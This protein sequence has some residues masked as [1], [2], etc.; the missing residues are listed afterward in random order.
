MW[1]KIEVVPSEHQIIFLPL[2]WEKHCK[3]PLKI[4]FSGKSVKV[5]VQF[6]EAEEIK[7]ENSFDKP[8]NIKISNKVKD[9]LLIQES[10]IYQIKIEDSSIVIGPVIGL[11]MG[12]DT[13]RYNPQHMNKYSDRFGIYPEVGGLIYGFSPKLINWDKH[14]VYGLYYNYGKGEW[15]YGDFPLPEVIYRRDF[16]TDPD[17][18]SKLVEYT[19]GRLFNSCRLTKY[20]LFDFIRQNS[21]LNQ[22]LPPTEL[23]MNLEQVIKFIDSHNKVILKPIDLS[24]GRGICIIEK[25]DCSYQI[26]DYRSKQPVVWFYHDQEALKEF[27][28][29]NTNLFDKYLIQKYLALAKIGESLFDIRV[30][31]Q[32]QKDKTWAC[33]GIEC[34]VSCPNSHLTNISRGGYALC[35][36]E[37][38]HQ[39][40]DS[41]HEL[42]SRKVKEIS[43]KF[44]DYMD[45]LKEHFAEFGLDIAID[46]DKNLWFIEANVFPSFKGFKSMDFLNY[47]SIRYTPLLY[48]LSLTKNGELNNGCSERDKQVEGDE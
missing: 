9:I 39:A 48:A 14:M 29:T 6:M 45:T 32:R 12:M 33:T 10:I 43:H 37:A 30:V 16:H 27:F 20:E 40:F 21:E 17:I 44:C 35:L 26:T 25:I 47:L 13:E 22:Y 5:S 36:D 1:A 7:G 46:L 19:G 2:E 8:I 31:M 38:L 34:R 3:E 41:E 28:D 15:E 11:L 18:I 23:S 24:R 42:L 4:E